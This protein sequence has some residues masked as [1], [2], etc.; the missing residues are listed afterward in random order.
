[1]IGFRNSLVDIHMRIHQETATRWKEAPVLSATHIHQIEWRGASMARL[2]IW[3]RERDPTHKLRGARTATVF[4]AAALLSGC[5]Q[6][7]QVWIEV[8]STSDNLQFIFGK[9]RGEERAIALGTLQVHKCNDTEVSL[10]QVGARERAVWWIHAPGKAPIISRL[11]YGETPAGFQTVAAP[12]SLS[13]GC[14]YV[15]VS[16][17][18]STTLTVDANGG[19]VERTPDDGR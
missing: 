6:K 11:K 4:F 5:P 13:E 3:L 15:S 17:T 1:M 18:A 12:R 2:R 19:I 14:Y 9:E 7:M 10:G 8:G 16:G